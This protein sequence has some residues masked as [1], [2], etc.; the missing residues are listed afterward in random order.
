MDIGMVSNSGGRS[1]NEDR[2]CVVE[3]AEGKGCFAVADGL[4]GHKGGDIAA[5]LVTDAIEKGFRAADDVSV[6]HLDALIKNAQKAL[7]KRAGEETVYRDM[8][9]T[10]AVLLLEHN[11]AVWAH[12]GDSRIYHFRD[13]KYISVTADHSVAYLAYKNGEMKYKD[14]RKSPDQNRL[15]RSIN[16]KGEVRADFGEAAIQ[17]G[18]AFLLCSDG[19][20]E[21]VDE[22]EMEKTIKKA[23]T[24]SRWLAKM[25]RVLE[26]NIPGS[27]YD[28][29]SAITIMV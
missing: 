20:W 2:I 12:V 28:N 6:Q 27:D 8:K 4:G 9:T 19:F 29:Y 5:E 23:R 7:E 24:A 16:A 3:S 26:K 1:V 13:G 22:T 14:I 17:P 15:L 18:D 10:L 11:R 25:M 21:L